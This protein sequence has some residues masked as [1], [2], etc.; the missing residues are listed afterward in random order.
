MRSTHL[1]P[2]SVCFFMLL[3]ADAQTNGATGK[4]PFDS[5]E[6]RAFNSLISFISADTLKVKTTATEQDPNRHLGE[7]HILVP[8]VQT[9]PGAGQMPSYSWDNMVPQVHNKEA[10]MGSPFLLTFY[11]PGLVINQYNT[12]INKPDYLYN[13]DK[14]SGNL[15][16]QRGND[17]PI[18]VNK[19][20]VKYFCLKEPKGGYIFEKVTDISPD[21][22]F[23]IIMK[24]PKYSFYKLY[25]N[26][27]ISSNQKTN[28]YIT[29]GNNYDEYKDVVD[30]YVIDHRKNEYQIFE[31][32]KSAIRKAIPA[33]TEFVNQYFKDHK[34]L[35]VDD[36]YLAQLAEALNK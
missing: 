30:Y 20:Q 24:G 7:E 8:A 4:Q 25:K 22:F 13:Y 19:E 21:E 31:L 33:D 34:I 1:L 36:L 14:M 32:K 18:A 15:L 35:D 26:K 9:Y 10:T 23:Q 17:K 29:E 12:V 3:N 2:I 6:V 16:L 11:V 5:L 28:G 27:F